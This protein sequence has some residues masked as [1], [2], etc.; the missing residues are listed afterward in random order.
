MASA[1]VLTEKSAEV[2]AFLQSPSKK[3]TRL[4]RR[5]V[6]VLNFPPIETPSHGVRPTIASGRIHSHTCQPSPPASTTRPIGP[7]NPNANG[8]PST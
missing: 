6:A 3:S 5:A 7:A 2:T 4:C 1:G 8:V